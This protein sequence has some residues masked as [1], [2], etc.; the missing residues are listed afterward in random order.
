MTTR[1]CT[2]TLGQKG[3]ATAVG[4][5]VGVGDGGFR[6]GVAVG[7]R[8]VLVGKTVTVGIGSGVSVGAGVWVGVAVLACV[9][10]GTKAVDDGAG[11]GIVQPVNSSRFMMSKPRT[12]FLTPRCT[13]VQVLQNIDADS[14]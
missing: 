5:G 2:Q 8:G 7:G 10:D 1:F 14:F 12:R 11:V 3:V 6:V 4:V 13:S 9:G